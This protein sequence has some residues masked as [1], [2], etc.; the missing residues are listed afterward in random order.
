MR[1]EKVGDRKLELT[2]SGELSLFFVGSGSAFTKKMN[3]TNIL[4]VKGNDHLMIDCGTKTPQALWEYGLPV[5]KI[6]N[7]FIT[8]THADHIGGLEEV[9][10]MNRYMMNLKR[11]NIYITPRFKK[12]L[13]NHS[14]RGGA[15]G[16]ENHKGRPLSFKDLWKAHTPAK[17]QGM[18]R[19]SWKFTVGELEIT[20]FR[21]MHTPDTSHSWKDSAWSTGLIIDN[22]VLFTS[23]TRFDPSLIEFA[24]KHWNIER[25]FHDCQF[26]D[27]GVHASINELDTLPDQVKERTFLMHYGDNWKDFEDRIRESKFIDLIR[28][29]C[30]YI[31]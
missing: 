5:Y 11:A 24:D 19:D 15:E 21:T 13:W 27:G 9:M 23:D 20:F 17:V 3:Q 31:F 22:K 16:N 28:E 30:F 14:L 18:E 4:I 12:A 8:H 6:D 10:L 29:G 1:I 26:F 25:I 7:F 2:N